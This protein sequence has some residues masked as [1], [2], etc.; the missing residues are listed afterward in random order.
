MFACADGFVI[1]TL[2]KFLST[3]ALSAT[4]STF[5]AQVSVAET[6]VAWGDSLTFGSGTQVPDTSAYTVWANAILPNAT[7]INEGLG[8]QSSTEIAARMGVVPLELELGEADGLSRAVTSYSVDVLRISGQPRG[9]L[10]GTF[11]GERGELTTDPEGNW[12]LSFETTVP[13][14]SAGCVSPRRGGRIW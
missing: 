6:I 1:K 14:A 12:S 11:D 9:R 5:S 2:G 4:L 3:F 7:I 10:K 8:G 13:P